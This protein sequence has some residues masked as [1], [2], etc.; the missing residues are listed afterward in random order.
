[1]RRYAVFVVLA[2]VGVILEVT[3]LPRILGTWVRP[4]L[5]FLVVIYLALNRPGGQ[6]TPAVLVIGY[7]TDVFSGL[8]DGTFLLVYLLCFYAAGLLAQILYFRGQVFPVVVA[9]MLSLVYVVVLSILSKLNT[10][11]S[12]FTFS[13]IFGF[14]GLNL[15]AALVLFPLC[16]RIDRWLGPVSPG[17]PGR[18]SHVLPGD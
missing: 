14:A 17:A 15:L 10:G 6:A 1:M 7:L 13:A 8:P 4:D 3:L 18:L 9:I 5:A 11:R 16:R 12:G 2:F